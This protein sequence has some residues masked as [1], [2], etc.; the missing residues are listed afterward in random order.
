MNVANLPLDHFWWF[1][2]VLSLGVILVT[3]IILK[4]KDLF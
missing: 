4:K 1:P 2:L 3:G